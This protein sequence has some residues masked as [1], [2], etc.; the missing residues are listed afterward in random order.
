MNGDLILQQYRVMSPAIGYWRAVIT[1]SQ[2]T[3]LTFFGFAKPPARL[4]VGQG[5]SSHLA[6]SPITVTAFLTQA[7]AVL[8][9]TVITAHLTYQDGTSTAVT[10]ADA[11]RPGD[12]TSG[13][14]RLGALLIAPTTS[15]LSF[16]S[17]VATNGLIAQS[18]LVPIY[19]R[20]QTGRLIGIAGER[21]VDEDGNGLANRLE[22]TASV[23][24][25]QAGAF[26]IVG[27]LEA[28]DGT[29]INAAHARVS[30]AAGMHSILLAWRGNDFVVA[31]KPGPYV[32]P[33]LQL[34][35]TSF[36]FFEVETRRNVFTT[37][38]YLVSQFE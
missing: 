32:M 18:A 22:I 4:V 19:I 9:G 14:G 33:V 17:V 8:P 3:T 12:M 36:Q 13:D 6:G 15:T 30:L 10:F 23:Y 28:L 2:P 34:R 37:T 25:S 27:T 11:G 26:E 5:A 16:L 7:G 1:A 38:H 29:Y 35:D 21:L 20:P 24:I 31:N